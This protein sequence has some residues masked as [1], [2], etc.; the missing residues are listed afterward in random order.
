MTLPRK[1]PLTKFGAIAAL[2][3]ALY[4]VQVYKSFFESKFGYV[5]EP[6]SDRLFQLKLVPEFNGCDWW[7]PLIPFTNC[8]FGKVSDAQYVGKVQEQLQR[9]EVNRR[10]FATDSKLAIQE[11]LREV[12]ASTSEDIVNLEISYFATRLPVAPGQIPESLRVLREFTERKSEDVFLADIV[13]SR[14][15]L[16]QSPL[17]YRPVTVEILRG[18]LFVRGAAAIAVLKV[19]N[20]FHSPQ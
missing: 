13:V 12:E 20:E 9:L 15:A 7:I 19:A 4:S 3:S 11:I 14:S 6:A 8:F 18:A 10:L 1:S 16:A 2:L 5:Y 17:K